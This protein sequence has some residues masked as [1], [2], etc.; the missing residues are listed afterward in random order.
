M[1]LIGILRFVRWVE[2][3]VNHVVQHSHCGADCFFQH[4]KIQLSVND[5]SQQIDRAEITDRSFRWRCVEQNLC[6][7]IAAVNHA[8][9]ILRRTQ[10]RWIFP[11]DPRMTGFEQTSQHLSP[12]LKS[13]QL[14]EHAD[15]ACF[16]HLLVLNVSS[17][18][19]FADQIVK[20]W[21]FVRAEQS[22][23][24]FF[25]NSFHEQ[26][27]NPVRRVHVVST[28]AIVTGVLAEIKEFL[29]VHVP[30]F[31]VRANRTLSLATL[32]YRN[33]C[34]VDDF[35]ERN[36]AL[37]ATVGSLDVGIGR[38]NAGPVVAQT[39]SPLA[40]LRVVGNALED[41][42]Q[43]VL[44]S[45]QVTGTELRMIGRRVEQRRRCGSKSHRGQHV[46]ELDR[47]LFRIIVT[48]SKAHRDSHPE[49]LRSLNA[50]TFD[51]QQI[52]VINRLQTRILEQSVSI[53]LQSR[54]DTSQVQVTQGVKRSSL[55]P[56]MT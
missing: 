50:T 7:E 42:L 43:V 9:V 30:G 56:S 54:G 4:R 3:D 36:H 6:A 38:S 41:V 49:V 2:V 32:I 44:H 48:K 51:V 52:T 45:R 13:W 26:V 19:G 8:D 17:F 27:R 5:V 46:I 35:Q 28:T 37:A 20:V 47:S 24:A 55:I 10:I 31:K 15:F 53:W 23:F 16:S 29:D 40:Q 14:L 11:G 1:F 22:P 33:G 12:Q 39:A 25:L 18:E 21:H 34:V